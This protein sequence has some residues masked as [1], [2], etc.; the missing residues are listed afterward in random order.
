MPTLDAQVEALAIAFVELSKFLG[1]KQH[2]AVTQLATMLKDA[3]KA[4]KASAETT[5]AVAELSRRL[6][7]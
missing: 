7:R 6:L 3:A 1:K 5:E 2:I 4:S